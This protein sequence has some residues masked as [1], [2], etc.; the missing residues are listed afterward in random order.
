[1]DKKVLLAYA[2][3]HGSTQEIATVVADTLREC[4]LTVDVLP[5]RSVRSLEGYSSVVLGAPLYIFH[6]QNDALRF[7]S[8]HRHVLTGGIPV[9]IFSSGPFGEGD[10]DEWNEVRRQLNQ[11]MMKFPWLKPV[12]VEVFGGKFD[13]TRLRFPWNLIPALKG[14]PA[15]DLRDWTAIRAWAS[16]LADN[17]V[18]PIQ[19]IQ[20]E[21]AEVLM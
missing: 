2:S 16:S 13:P 14:I 6:L 11:E 19:D 5:A 1:M 12:A 18:P 4:R 17:L 21:I 3:I 15:K 8:R 20:T 9:A 7:L 10:A